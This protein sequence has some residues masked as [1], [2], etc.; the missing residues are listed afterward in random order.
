MLL[1][2]SV[3]II[4]VMVLPSIFKVLTVLFPVSI[5]SPLDTYH[6]YHDFCKAFV[7]AVEQNCDLH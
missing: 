4:E 5:Q 3:L 2:C 1:I 6:S 7:D